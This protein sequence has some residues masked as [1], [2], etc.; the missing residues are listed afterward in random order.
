MNVTLNS[1]P[2][3]ALACLSRRGFTLIELLVVIAII[4][5]LAAMLLPALARAKAKAIQTQ[6]LSNFRQVN[7]ALKMYVDDNNDWLCGQATEGLLIGQSAAYIQ[8]APYNMI[9]YVATYLGL[10]QPDS[11][12]RFAKVMVC[13]AY[14]R[15]LKDPNSATNNVQYTVPNG[16]AGDPGDGKG[17][18]I[19]F[20]PGEKPLPWAI[21]GYPNPWPSAPRKISEIAA[22]KPLTEVWALGDADQEGTPGAGWSSTLPPKPSHGTKRN[23]LFLDGHTA[24]RKAIK[25][26]W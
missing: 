25:G 16:G 12:M 23:Y 14:E 18:S 9:Y 11:Q 1:R 2:R 26:Y 20:G 24:T 3:R 15:F 4:A 7:I 10:P 6:C 19:C 13:P 21:F 22:E 5:I 17:G 8:G